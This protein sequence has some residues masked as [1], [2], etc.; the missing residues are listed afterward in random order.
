[1]KRT[2]TS[3]H[4]STTSGW[5]QLQR[6]SHS[7]IVREPMH[8]WPIQRISCNIVHG[9]WLPMSN[10]V[11]WVGKEIKT[12][13][14][15]R[16]KGWFKSRGGNLASWVVDFSILTWNVSNISQ[17]F[18]KS[19]V[20]LEISQELSFHHQHVTRLKNSVN[21]KSLLLWWSLCCRIGCFLGFYGKGF[22][23]VH[24]G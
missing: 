12:W 15:L 2:E 23:L 8:K 21:Q 13:N 6:N 5:C 24:H 18:R 11:F 1:M 4:V 14:C 19:S 17:S 9:G 20:I 16:R 22:G 7:K 3:L 10:G